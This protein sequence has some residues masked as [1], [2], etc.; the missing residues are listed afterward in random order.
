MSL[1]PEENLLDAS[2]RDAF[3][4]YH[5]SPAEHMHVWNGVEK[6]IAT[7]ALPRKALLSFRLVLPLAAALGVGVAV[8]WLLPRPTS[9]PPH[10]PAVPTVRT[11]TWTAPAPPAMPRVAPAAVG[12]RPA[13]PVLG[14][15][16]A[17]A[18]K[19]L[20]SING[21]SDAK[22]KGPVA[23]AAAV[24]VV[25]PVA[26]A[27]VAKVLVASS[28]SVAPAAVPSDLVM[29]A[30]M[31]TPNDSS[32]PASPRPTPALAPT[33]RADAGPVSST[34]PKEAAAPAAKAAKPDRVN[35]KMLYRKPTHRQPEHGVG[36]IRRWFSRL[37]Q[38]IRH[39]F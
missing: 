22:T 13:N 38:G 37:T 6:R 33:A 25:Q 3:R 27:G 2:L 18:A 34:A 39:S 12:R 31:P 14:P 19:P 35:E 17:V 23:K 10:P 15:W 11:S 8:G 4:D 36:G 1:N 30:P 24:A 28:D 7:L 9:P 20:L 26:G 29:A 16:K 32:L 21:H 5:L